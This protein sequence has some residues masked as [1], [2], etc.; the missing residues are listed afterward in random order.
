MAGVSMVVIGGAG[1]LSSG[2]ASHSRMRTAPR[3]TFVG[4]VLA[5]VLLI[6]VGATLIASG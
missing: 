4:L 5:G 6:T 1:L 3:R 2:S